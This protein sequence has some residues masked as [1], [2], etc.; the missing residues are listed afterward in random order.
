MIYETHIFKLGCTY[1]GIWNFNTQECFQKKLLSIGIKNNLKI[2][3]KHVPFIKIYIFSKTFF[4]YLQLPDATIF[5]QIH[6]AC[7]DTVLTLW[8]IFIKKI[9]IFK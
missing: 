1:G 8:D 7:I 2:H 4:Y 5:C 3:W 9:E 6:D